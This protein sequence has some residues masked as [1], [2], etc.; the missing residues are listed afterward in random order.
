MHGTNGAQI[1]GGPQTHQSM[2]AGKFV[3]NAW[4]M[5]G[6]GEEV[7][8][9]KFLNRVILNEPVV[10][11]RNK[12][13]SLRALENRCPHRFAPLSLGKVLDN[14]NLQCGYHGLEFDKD[15][16]CVNNPHKGGNVPNNAKVASY[17]AVEK[18]R[19]IWIWM[20][21]KEPDM[22]TIPDFSVIA[23]PAPL[24]DTALDMIKVEANYKLIVDNLLDLSHVAYLHVGTL[25][26]A[27]S[28]DAS[29]D[30]TEDGEDLLVTRVASGVEAVAMHGMQWPDHPD[31][32]DHF[33]QIRWM[34]PSCLNLYVGITEVGKPWEEGTGIWATHMLTPETDSSTHYF[35]TATRFG[36]RDMSEEQHKEIQ[37]KIGV[38]RRYAFEV[39]DGPMIAAQQDVIDTAPRSLE[40]ANINVDLGAVRFR[41]AI[42]RMEAAD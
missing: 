32:I 17:T 2:T 31:K 29:I 37:H 28:V 6:W 8:D 25:G 20:G 27:Q 7:D 35:F 42:S 19:C 9:G 18:H 33:Q 10:I 24:T 38:M 15:G 5:A 13:G 16:I 23:D 4:Y 34:A 21:E 30:V 14:G 11:F 1:N 40:P 39:E 41:R 3:T 12:D 26:N 22:T 36:L